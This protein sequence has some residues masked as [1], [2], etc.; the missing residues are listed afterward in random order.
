MHLNFFFIFNWEKKKKKKKHSLLLRCFYLFF[1]YCNS[2]QVVHVI[3]K[4]KT[5]L[6]PPIIQRINHLDS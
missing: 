1:I 4:Y 5:F 2:Y 6:D 3:Y